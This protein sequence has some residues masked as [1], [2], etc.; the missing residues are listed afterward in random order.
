MRVP[1]KSIRNRQRD[2]QGETMPEETVNS[3][4]TMAAAFD[5]EA[6]VTPDPVE[7]KPA[8]QEPTEVKS[9]DLQVQCRD[10]L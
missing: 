1:R 7:A 8:V 10:Q 3:P 9:E 2:P 6:G 5:G 4:E